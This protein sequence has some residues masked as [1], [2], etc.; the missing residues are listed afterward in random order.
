MLIRPNVV[1]L[2]RVLEMQP[3]LC[4]QLIILLLIDYM[5]PILKQPLRF[6]ESEKL[7]ISL[8]NWLKFH[9]EEFHALKKLVMRYQRR[10]ERHGDH[11]FHLIIIEVETIKRNLLKI[12]VH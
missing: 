12:H 6:E 2:N 8:K 3:L 10:L 9:A 7:K 11:R 1:T 4:C 5:E